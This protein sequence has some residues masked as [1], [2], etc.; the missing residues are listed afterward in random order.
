MRRALL[1]LALALTGL[2]AAC[3]SSAAKTEDKQAVALLA[4]VRTAIQ[5]AGSVRFADVTT[6]GTQSQSI[7][8]AFSPTASTE[9]LA[10]AQNTYVSVR[11]RGDQA[12]VKTNSTDSLTQVLGI[13]DTKAASYKDTWISLTSTDSAYANI[14]QTM[15]VAQVVDLYLPTRATATMGTPKTI[16]GHA[17]LALTASASESSGLKT[18]TTIYVDATTKLPILGTMSATQHSTSESKHCGFLDWGVPVGVEAPSG[19]VSLS[20]IL[21]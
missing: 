6:I 2:T 9:E 4:Q 14:L 11:A 19:A 15:T 12:W 1:S 5:T 3:G 17:T 8:G 10:G 16:D 18:T 21:S 13:S 7:S 20:S